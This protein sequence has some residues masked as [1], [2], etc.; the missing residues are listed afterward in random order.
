[1]YLVRLMWRSASES[2]PVHS[3]YSRLNQAWRTV[4]FLRS[5]FLWESLVWPTS[6]LKKTTWGK[7]RRTAKPIRMKSAVSNWFRRRTPYRTVSEPGLRQKLIKSILCLRQKMIKSIPC[8][9]QKSRKKYPGWP[10]VPLSLHKGIPPCPPP[11]PQHYISC[12]FY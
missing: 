1:M 11:R 3:R 6:S 10:H 7:S 5:P 8:L 2:K 4:D 12:S 9:R